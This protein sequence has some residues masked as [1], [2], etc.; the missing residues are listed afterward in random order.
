M[1]EDFKQKSYTVK[2]M[3]ILFENWRR[4]VEIPPYEMKQPKPKTSFLKMFKPKDSS[5]ASTDTKAKTNIQST[6]NHK[7]FTKDGKGIILIL[8]IIIFL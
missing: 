2:Q 6:K 8:I 7:K 1:L 3:E 4:K 5:T